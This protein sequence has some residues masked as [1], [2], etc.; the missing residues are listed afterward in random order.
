MP[1]WAGNANKLGSFTF[2]EH[3]DS[4]QLSLAASAGV[5]SIV[6][7]NWENVTNLSG[8]TLSLLLRIITLYKCALLSEFELLFSRVTVGVGRSLQ[9]NNLCQ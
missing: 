8:Q 1:G 2:L 3:F 6:I 9:I 4:P 7:K 5:S